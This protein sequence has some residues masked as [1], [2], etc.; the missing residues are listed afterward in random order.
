[1]SMLLLSY[2]LVISCAFVTK[3]RDGER[4]ELVTQTECHNE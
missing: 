4:Q 1:M 3:N 2:E